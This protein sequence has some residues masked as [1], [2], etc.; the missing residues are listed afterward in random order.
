MIL[1]TISLFLS[2]C[3]F[4][5][6]AGVRAETVADFFRGKTINV[7]VGYPPGGAYDT[8]AR[9][10]ARFMGRYLPGNPL[11]LIRQMPGGGSR[12]AVGYMANVAPRDGTYLATADQ[13]LATQQAIGDPTIL[14]DA[15]KLN[16][17]G[18]PTSDNNTLAVSAATGVKT[19]AD[20]T[21][22]E[23]II[24]ASGFNTTSQYPQALNTIAG[25]RFRIVLG[26]PGAMELE[27]ALERDEIGGATNPWSSWMVQ[28]PEWI[29][30]KRINILVQGGLKRMKEMPDVPL[31][32]E[33]AT[34]DLDREALKLFSAATAF[35]RPLF[36]TPGVPAERVAALREAFDQTMKDPDFLSAA[37]T[38]GYNIDPVSGQSLQELAQ[39][40]V[41]EPKAVT[42]RLSEI[43]AL[44]SQEKK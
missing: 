27:L 20:A 43:I 31:L 38:S 10:I 3:F 21:T 44:P 25:T 19:I 4:L 9:L 6:T 22:K 40:I 23:I 13:S 41:S 5:V 29:R 24:G 37:A 11:F 14:F 35:G 8:Y 17:I 12:I 15:S 42:E 26:Y 30:D 39:E 28:K 33:L 34:N 32:T 7:I 16:W 36:S 2:A 18:N 1:R